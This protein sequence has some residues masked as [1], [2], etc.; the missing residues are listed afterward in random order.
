MSYYFSP[1]S[2][3]A[4][5]TEAEVVVEPVPPLPPPEPPL[6]PL[7]PEVEVVS[8]VVRVSRSVY[9]VENRIG[10]ALTIGTIASSDTIVF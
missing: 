6:P 5:E 1:L 2:V 9:F 4:D 8:V 7:P 3:R 10:N